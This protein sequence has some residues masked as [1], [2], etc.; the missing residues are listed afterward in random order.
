MARN[1]LDG[2]HRDP[3]GRIDQKHGKMRIGS[4]PQALR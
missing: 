4:L 3:T 2:R 1:G